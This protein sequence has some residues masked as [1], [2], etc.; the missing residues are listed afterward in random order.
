MP[1]D[2]RTKKTHW[3]MI[4]RKCATHLLWWYA[5]YITCSCIQLIHCAFY[6]CRRWSTFCGWRKMKTLVY[7]PF[8]RITS[9]N[10]PTHHRIL[11]RTIAPV[12]A[13]TLIKGI[14]IFDN[15]IMC[16][17][18]TFFLLICHQVATPQTTIQKSKNHRWTNLCK[19][20]PPLNS[21]ASYSK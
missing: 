12:R 1:I 7:L 16:G 4:W 19:S 14:R 2:F 8:V 21:H 20:L 5:I 3:T 18:L 13:H 9:V 15:I 17:I 6:F 11:P 10:V